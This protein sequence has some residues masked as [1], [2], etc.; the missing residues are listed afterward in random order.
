MRA[1]MTSWENTPGRPTQIGKNL[2]PQAKRSTVTV[3]KRDTTAARAPATGASF[4]G[5]CANKTRVLS[6]HHFSQGLREYFVVVI[7][8]LGSELFVPLSP[9]HSLT[10]SL[11]LR[12]IHCMMQTAAL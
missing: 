6:L 12:Q 2:Q 10:T 11:E 9:C 1:V 4:L 8:R 7:V 5:N 3:C